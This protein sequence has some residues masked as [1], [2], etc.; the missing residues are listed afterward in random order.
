MDYISNSIEQYDDRKVKILTGIVLYNPDL[1]RLKENIC[2]IASQVDEIVLV[3]NGSN[4]IAMIE[5]IYSN[6]PKISILKNSQNLGI[7]KALEEIL[8]V[9]IKKGYNWVLTLDQDS[10][11]K[12]ELIKKYLKYSN[13]HNVGIMS[14]NIIDRNFESLSVCEK[15]V[16]YQ[17]ILYCITSASFINVEAYLKTDGFD[18]KMFIDCV[19]FDICIKMREK[20]YRIIRINYDGILH[21]VGHGRNVNFLGKKYEIYNHS[22]FRHY[23]MA[24]N[25]FYLSR[26]YPYEF[27]RYRVILRECRMWLF[28]LLYEEDKLGKISARMKGIADSGRMY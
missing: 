3:D 11:C 7:A 16:D 13:L 14:C 23:Y 10:V 20:G 18:E 12:D 17:E 9:A 2:A 8:D 21:E 27:K 15:G 22:A 1:S 26:K 25:R 6:I 24:R 4:N 28:I 19:D 5:K